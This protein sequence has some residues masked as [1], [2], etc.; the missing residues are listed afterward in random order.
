MG[1]HNEELFGPQHVSQGG[2][3]FSY[4]SYMRSLTLY[5][6]PVSLEVTWKKRLH[7]AFKNFI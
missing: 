6:V 4:Y 2:Y 5:L 7:L 3:L 1:R